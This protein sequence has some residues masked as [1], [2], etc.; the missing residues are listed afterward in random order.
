MLT[1][2]Q[3]YSRLEKNL[4]TK[5]K[6]ELIV[7]S[8][9]NEV[10]PIS[11]NLNRSKNVLQRFLNNNRSIEGSVYLS[12]FKDITSYNLRHIINKQP[13]T[14]GFI[15]NRDKT[16]FI[17]VTDVKELLREIPS[18]NNIEIE[19]SLIHKALFLNL[20]CVLSWIEVELVSDD[21]V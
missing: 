4:R 13:S 21:T 10:N 17:S 12:G 11:D 3:R 8:L 1:R 18:S 5:V 2:K 15:F 14:L 7:I 6:E 20:L 16:S 19:N 9:L